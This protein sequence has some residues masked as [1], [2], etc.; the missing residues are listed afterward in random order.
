MNNSSFKLGRI[1]VPDKRDGNFPLR[2]MLPKAPTVRTYRYW[3]P[4][5]WW[6]DQGSTSECVAFSWCHWLA[7]GPITQKQ[8]TK[9][10][11]IVDP[12]YLYAEAQKVDEWPGENY[13]GTSVR[14]GAKILMRDGFIS[15]YNWAWDIDTVVSALLS[16]GPLVVGTNW[17]D[18]M[19]YPD[20][21]SKISVSGNLAGGHAYLL[22]GVNTKTGLIRIKNS[23][24][25]GWGHSGFAYISISDMGRLISEEGEACL[26]V[27]IKK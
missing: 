2:S 27:E 1:S 10:T 8:T 15:S 22:D 23:W 14:A 11:S 17:Y 9:G 20:A 6:G 19:F 7:E 4:N 3:W 5:G 16:V 25:K 13:D 26:A 12:N 21:N 18:G 24:G